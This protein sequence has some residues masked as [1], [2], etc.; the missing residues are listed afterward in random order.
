MIDKNIKSRAVMFVKS[1]M[2]RV[3]RDLESGI[4]TR[5]QAIGSLN[6]L[7]NIA[8]GIEDTMQMQMICRMISYIRTTSFYGQIKKM[9]ANKMFHDQPAPTSAPVPMQVPAA[10]EIAASSMKILEKIVR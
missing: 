3:V 9:Y 2:E 4:I 10:E 6:T 5:D 8:S 1:D 7:F